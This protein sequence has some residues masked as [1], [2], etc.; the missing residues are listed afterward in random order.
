MVELRDRL[1]EPSL[2]RWNVF[3]ESRSR[4]ISFSLNVEKNITPPGIRSGSGAF[5]NLIN[6]GGALIAGR[7]DASSGEGSED[8]KSTTLAVQVES[9][10]HQLRQKRWWW[11]NCGSSCCDGDD[12]VHASGGE[13]STVVNEPTMTRVR[14]NRIGDDE[15]PLSDVDIA[16]VVVADA[17]VDACLMAVTKHRDR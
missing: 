10:R 4:A 7:C 17:D 12:S 2:A 3:P 1:D 6:R 15:E 9:H 14:Y 8:L 5:G 16:V 13:T 11:M